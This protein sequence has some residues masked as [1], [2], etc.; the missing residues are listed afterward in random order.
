MA[1]FASIL[2]P[3]IGFFNMFDGI[4]AIANSHVFVANADYVNGG[5]GPGAGR[6]LSSA[7]GA[8]RGGG[9][10]WATSGPLVAVAVAA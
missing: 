4:A 6:P 10:C 9:S 5:C 2:P 3:T 8:D 1:L 7:L